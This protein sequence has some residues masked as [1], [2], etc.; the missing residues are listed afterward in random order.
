[1]RGGPE[2]GVQISAAGGHS[3]VWRDDE[4][5][6]ISTDSQLISAPVRIIGDAIVEI[7]ESVAL[8][9]VPRGSEFDVSDDGEIFLVDRS[10]DPELLAPIVVLTDWAD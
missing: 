8:F 9:R 3:P 4:V 6:F 7:G 5:F 10:V 2:S 1:V